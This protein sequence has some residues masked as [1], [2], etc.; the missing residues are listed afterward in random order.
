MPNIHP[1][2]MAEKFGHRRLALKPG[3][4]LGEHGQLTKG[5][6]YFK[7]GRT[8]GICNGAL[9]YC[10]WNDAER[11]RY[12]NGDPVQMSPEVTEEFIILSQ[13]SDQT[14]IEQDSFCESGDSGSLIVDREGDICGLLYG[15]CWG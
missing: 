4:P 7:I 3:D 15:A 14:T 5:E 9:P 2:D 13:R 10:H 12:F 6:W 1:K 8:T 11:T